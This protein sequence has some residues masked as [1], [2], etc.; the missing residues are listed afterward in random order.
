MSAYMVEKE[1]VAYLVE[2]AVTHALA[3]GDGGSMMWRGVSG[4]EK[5]G[6]YCEIRCMADGA[7]K[8]QVGN[9]LW[10]ANEESIRARYGDC[11]TATDYPGNGRDAETGYTLTAGDFRRPPTHIDPVQVLK[12]CACFR[13]Q[14]CEFAGWD[15]SEAARF[16]EALTT[17]AINSLP[18][19]EEAVWGAPKK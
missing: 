9:M 3:R 4:P 7:E 10:R 18:G 16:I 1:H 14:A 11:K 8:A 12:S 17:K 2:A 6:P 5:R 19:Y 13:Y 15:D